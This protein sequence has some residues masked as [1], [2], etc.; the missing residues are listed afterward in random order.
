MAEQGLTEDEFADRFQKAI[1]SDVK[2]QQYLDIVLASMDYQA[3][4]QLMKCM[5]SRAALENRRA[6]AKDAHASA[7]HELKSGK[8]KMGDGSKDSEDNPTE[9]DA[10]GDG[11]EP[12]AKES[13]SKD[14]K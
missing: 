2:A 13:G 10:K 12:S 4:Y 5:R 7:G 11:D 3:F 8:R 1:K 6:E 14:S 9:A